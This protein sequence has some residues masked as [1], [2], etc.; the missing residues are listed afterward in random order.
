[1]VLSLAKMRLES[2]TL[3]SIYVGLLT[4]LFYILNL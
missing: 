3:K 4:K 1:M 2:E